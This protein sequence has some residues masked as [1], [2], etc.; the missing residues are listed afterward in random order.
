MRFLVAMTLVVLM[1]M[2]AEAGPF[3]RRTSRGGSVAATS[4]DVSSAGAVARLMAR[5]GRVGH[6]GG[7]N[8]RE[9]CGMGATPQA[10]LA[11]CCY[12]RSGLRVADQAVAQASNG[13]WY[14]CKRYAG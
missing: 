12:S 7:W 6:W 2:D 5:V 1:T 13:M 10:A 9:G 11:N 8:G 4:A 3:R 14:A